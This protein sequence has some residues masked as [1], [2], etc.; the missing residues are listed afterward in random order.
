MSTPEG[1][2]VGMNPP[3]PASFEN[4]MKKDLFGAHSASE[5]VARCRDESYWLGLA[6][7]GNWATGLGPAADKVPSR[8]H[9]VPLDVLEKD[10]FLPPQ[11][12]LS[13]EDAV[14]LALLFE[15]VAR[16]GWPRIFG[17]L[18]Q[19][20]WQALGRPLFQDL[21]RTLFGPDG[22]QLPGLWVHHVPAVGG[23]R[24][25]EPHLDVA[26]KTVTCAN[27]GP[28]RLSIWIALKKADLENGCMFVVP[29]SLAPTSPTFHGR[30][31]FEASEVMDFLHGARPLVA[32]PGE[33]I[34]WHYDTLHWG[35]IATGQTNQPRLALSLE[36]L[37]EESAPQ[38]HE[39]PL[40]KPGQVPDFEQRL[41]LVGRNLRAYAG[42]AEREPHAHRFFFM[43]EA[44]APGA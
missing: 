12:V 2:I 14:Q 34:G 8:T 15:Q 39:R 13:T 43:G 6:E 36:F 20:P 27:G 26:H 24:G 7:G 38:R 21:V 3:R 42:D 9:H 41:F 18:F 29:K 32:E 23:A 28:D 31:T 10:G 40:L 44:L 16:A 4:R 11:R 19:A 5:L 35:G 30:G 33:A 17:L 37:N 25:W 1:H 22:T